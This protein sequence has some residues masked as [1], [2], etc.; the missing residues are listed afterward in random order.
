MFGRARVEN[1]IIFTII[2]YLTFFLV[3]IDICNANS[4]VFLTF[5]LNLLN[6]L[7]K[8]KHQVERLV[9]LKSRFNKNFYVEI[10]QCVKHFAD[11][12]K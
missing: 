4:V 7:L 10:I 9:K 12:K 6:K 5:G 8:F 3:K 11:F 1:N 2:Q